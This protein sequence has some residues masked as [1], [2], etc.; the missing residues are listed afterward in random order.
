MGVGRAIHSTYL[1]Y[2]SL[3]P[4]IRLLLHGQ[5]SALTTFPLFM[6][7]IWSFT[8]TFRNLTSTCSSEDDTEDV[9][10][11]HN[12][13]TFLFCDCSTVTLVI[14]TFASEILSSE[15][16]NVIKALTHC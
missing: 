7:N 16:S 15:S 4:T 3:L 10:T 5:I 13:L 11:M 14:L 8:V 9:K 12:N 6:L 1:G 2:R